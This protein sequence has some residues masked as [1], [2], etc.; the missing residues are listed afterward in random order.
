VPFVGK[1]RIQGL[2]AVRGTYRLAYTVRAAPS[3]ASTSHSSLPLV[4]LTAYPPDFL[5]RLRGN[6]FGSQATVLRVVPFFGK[7]RIDGLEAV[8]F[9]Y[10]FPPTVWAAITLAPATYGSLPLMAL[11]THPPDFSVGPCGNVFGSQ[12]SVPRGVPF[13]GKSWIDGLEAVIFINGFS[14]AVWASSPTASLID[15]SFPFVTLAA[16]P[17]DPLIGT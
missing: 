16:Y 2:E 14:Y 6:I 12:A 10:G 4:T 9:T 7:N 3:T 15:G 13:F 8:V 17:P 1:G 5:V 11:A